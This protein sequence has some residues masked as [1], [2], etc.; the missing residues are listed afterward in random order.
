M[1]TYDFVQ[2]LMMEALV[3]RIEDTKQFLKPKELG[4]NDPRKISKHLAPASPAPTRQ[5]AEKKSLGF[6][7]IEL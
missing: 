5:L 4:P 3:S 7:E 6:N 2:E 1:K